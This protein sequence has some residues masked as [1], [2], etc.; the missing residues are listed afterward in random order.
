[1][2]GDIWVRGS[3]RYASGDGKFET[4]VPVPDLLLVQREPYGGWAPPAV[5]GVDLM[6]TRLEHADSA[7]SSASQSGVPRLA[8]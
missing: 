8:V 5:A 3:S 1:V 4:E 6:L 7:Q 2:T